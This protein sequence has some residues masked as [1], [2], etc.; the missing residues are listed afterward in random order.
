MLGTGRRGANNLTDMV[1][2]FREKSGLECPDRYMDYADTN[3][4]W[5]DN[6]T[7]AKRD[8][9]APSATTLVGRTRSSKLGCGQPEIETPLIMHLQYRDV[10]LPTC[11]L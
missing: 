6:G 7:A 1:D 4:D 5:T 2:L 10:V 3:I 11:T 8:S 9:A